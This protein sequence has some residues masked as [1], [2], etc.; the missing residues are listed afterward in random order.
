MIKI[1]DFECQ[2]CKQVTEIFLDTRET[3]QE[4]TCEHCKKKTEMKPVLSVGAG[5]KTHSSWARWRL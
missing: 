5:D 4:I 2:E 1:Q 3:E